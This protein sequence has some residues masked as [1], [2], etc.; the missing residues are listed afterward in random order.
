MLVDLRFQ[1][2]YSPKSLIDL[3]LPVAVNTNWVYKLPM[4]DGDGAQVTC[5]YT[6]PTISTGNLPPTPLSVNGSDMDVASDCT[7]R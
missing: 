5:R 6:A 4:V 1:N 2:T 3:V 7:L